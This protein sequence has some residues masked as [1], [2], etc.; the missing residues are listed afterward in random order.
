VPLDRHSSRRVAPPEGP[1]PPLP[2][3]PGLDPR[4]VRRL[5]TWVLRHGIGRFRA[6]MAAQALYDLTMRLRELRKCG[7]GSGP[8]WC[9][10]GWPAH[11]V[12]ERESTA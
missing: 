2:T 12:T 11:L 9:G 7:S 10:D 1:Q 4:L 8:V 3:Q 6:I 5:S